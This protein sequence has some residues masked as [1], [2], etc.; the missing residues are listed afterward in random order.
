MGSIATL[1]EGEASG[2]VHSE[3]D[4]GI[5]DGPCEEKGKRRTEPGAKHLQGRN[6]Q[7]KPRGQNG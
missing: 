7:W 3:H 2:R 4:R 5:L 1:G 6:Q